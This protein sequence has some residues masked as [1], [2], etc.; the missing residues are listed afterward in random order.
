MNQKLIA[1]SNFVLSQVLNSE[2]SLDILQDF[3]EAILK[4]KIEEI[5]LNNHKGENVVTS[6]NFGIADVR[7]KTEDKK[8]INV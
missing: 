7:I 4:I 3:I 1:K 2:D 6:K 8:E 5:K